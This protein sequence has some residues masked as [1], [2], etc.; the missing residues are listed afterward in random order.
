MVEIPVWMKSEGLSLA[1]GLIAAPTMSSSFSGTIFA[2]PSRGS[3]A[4][5]RTLPSMS[6]ETGIFMVSP[7][8]RTDASLSIPVVPSNT[9]TTTMSSEESRTSPLFMVPSDILM[10]TISLYPT[11]SV[12]LTKMRGPAIWEIVLYSLVMSAI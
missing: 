3:P 11:G 9:W 1:Q 2:P 12:F 10:L 4:P 6:L 8:K 5:E 7:R